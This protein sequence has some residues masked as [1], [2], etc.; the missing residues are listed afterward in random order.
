MSCCEEGYYP[1]YLLPVT[2]NTATCPGSS[3]RAS[4]KPSLIPSSSLYS[5]PSL[6]S[7]ILSSTPRSIIWMVHTFFC[8]GIWKIHEPEV[9]SCKERK[10]PYKDLYWKENT[11]DCEAGDLDSSPHSVWH[12]MWHPFFR[13]GFPMDEERVLK[14]AGGGGQGQTLI[15]R[16]HT[17]YFAEN[18]ITVIF[19]RFW[20]SSVLVILY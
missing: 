1:E 6:Y 7:Q 10:I 4:V 8:V 15:L 14:W 11:A 19:K 20:G 5:D 16:Q 3:Y 2:E 17:F 9:H 12:G 18:I 13:A